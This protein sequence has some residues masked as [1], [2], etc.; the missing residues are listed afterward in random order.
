MM[1]A[2]EEAPD[3]CELTPLRADDP[4]CCRPFSTMM[5]TS[6]PSAE[7]VRCGWLSHAL[8]MLSSRPLP[9]QPTPP[10]QSSISCSS[11]ASE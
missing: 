8:Q 5:K 1:K 4:Y 2:R 6:L 3:F 10:H 11:A 7:C 9:I